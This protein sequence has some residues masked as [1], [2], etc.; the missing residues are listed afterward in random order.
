VSIFV[1]YLL[2]WVQENPWRSA[3]FAAVV[4]TLGQILHSI[5]GRWIPMF[6]TWQYWPPV[7]WFL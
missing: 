4:L 5:G 6:L 2:A 7:C 1:L 3:R